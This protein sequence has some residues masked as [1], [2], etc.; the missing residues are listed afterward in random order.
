L[1]FSKLQHTAD[2]P[3]AYSVLVAHLQLFGMTL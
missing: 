2:I 1:N 3:C